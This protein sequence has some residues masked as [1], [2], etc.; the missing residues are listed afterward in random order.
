LPSFRGV[1]RPNRLYS[2]PF[3]RANNTK[4]RE[5]RFAPPS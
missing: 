1:V 4:E 2:R 3:F 5:T